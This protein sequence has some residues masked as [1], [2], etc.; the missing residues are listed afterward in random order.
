MTQPPSIEDLTV[1]LRTDIDA[2]WQRILRE[3][4]DLE[5]TWLDLT[6]PQRL[7]RLRALQANV[8]TLADSAD[9]IAAR[10]ITGAMR[11]AYETGAWATA[12]V[13]AT[14]AVFD[15]VD[16]DAVTRLAQDTMNDL[17]HATRGVRDSTKSMVRMMTRDWV[18]TKLYTGL[19]AEQ[20]GVRLAADLTDHGITSLIYANGNRVGLSTYTDMVTRTRT[21]E[22]YQ[23]GGFNQ[24]ER[25]GIEWWEVFDGDSCGWEFHDD[26][27]TANGMIVTL[28]D[29]QA[30]P[31]SHPNCQRSTSPRPDIH[32]AAEARHAEQ[33]TTAQQ[34]TDQAAAETARAAAHAQIPRRVGLDRRVAASRQ[35]S[36]DLQIG[37][38]RSPAQQRHLARLATKGPTPAL[39]SE[40]ATRVV[41][42]ATAVE[43]GLTTGMTALAGQVGGTMAGLDFRLKSVKSLTEKITEDVLAS[44]RT[45]QQAADHIFDV[46][47][48]TILLK[49]DQYA[50]SAQAAIDQLRADGNAIKVKNYWRV[51]LTTNPYQG[52]NVQITKQGGQRLE[53][54]FHTEVSLHVK[55]HELHD[56]YDLSK[57]EKDPLKLAEYMRQEA[58]A[59]EKIPVPRGVAAV[60]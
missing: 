14:S 37:V 23:A 43:P 28:D 31:I 38:V 46:N 53:L 34:R 35:R 55:E 39:P 40:V 22:A 54:Q 59:S 57:T 13:A 60:S 7:R 4:I 8:R 51:P 18:R 32:N 17:L 56:I 52:I 26:T 47:R 41:A 48:Y 2:V 9:E 12:T 1:A 15:A 42:A 6:P 20:A 49:P 19:T 27:Q 21:A 25:L 16:L 24:G 5:Q 45:A 44:K 36:Q 3:Q 58:A 10:H 29:A 33:T 11:D 30:Y 50:R